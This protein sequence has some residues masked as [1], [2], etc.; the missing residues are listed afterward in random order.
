AGRRGAGGAAR[1]A[2]SSAFAA[3][4]ARHRGVSSSVQGFHRVGRCAPASQRYSDFTAPQVEAR[5]GVASGTQ[6]N[7]VYRWG[8]VSNGG[9]SQSWCTS[10]GNPLCQV[11]YWLARP[12]APFCRSTLLAWT[13]VVTVTR[14][15]KI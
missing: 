15:R 4:A 3:A 2:S 10:V 1:D 9:V 13:G 12:F 5:A 8:H 7:A 11:A 14:E 6:V